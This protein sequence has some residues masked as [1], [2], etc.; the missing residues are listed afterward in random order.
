MGLETIS[1]Q[2][3]G[4]RL[5]FVWLYLFALPFQL[6]DLFGWYTIPGVGI[7]SFIY[8][9]FFL[10]AMAMKAVSVH[11]SMVSAMDGG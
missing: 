3:S 5:R 7:A 4:T 9:G 11:T 2:Q 10:S 1:S 8:L 6:V